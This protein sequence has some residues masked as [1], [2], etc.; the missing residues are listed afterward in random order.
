MNIPIKQDTARRLGLR[1]PA[2]NTYRS[3]ALP[4]GWNAGGLTNP[5][6][7]PA[8]MH[9]LFE[10]IDWAAVQRRLLIAMFGGRL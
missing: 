3:S 10:S 7:Q 2:A 6:P 8:S 1:R 5:Q 4:P 9:E